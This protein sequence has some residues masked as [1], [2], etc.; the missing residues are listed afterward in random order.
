MSIDENNGFNSNTLAMEIDNGYSVITDSDGNPIIHAGEVLEGFMTSSAVTNNKVCV[1][2]ASATE[3][4]ENGELFTV[5][6]TPSAAEMS[7]Y[8]TTESAATIVT[9]AQN[10]ARSAGIQIGDVDYNGSINSM[11]AASL[12]VACGRNQIGDSNTNIMPILYAYLKRD[13]S[14]S[15][16][17]DIVGKYR[18][19]YTDENNTE[20]PID[21]R[22]MNCYDESYCVVAANR[23]DTRMINGNDSQE[24]LKYSA[25]IGSGGSYTGMVGMDIDSVET[26]NTVSIA[27]NEVAVTATTKSII[28]EYNMNVPILTT[29]TVDGNNTYWLPALI[30][31]YNYTNNASLNPVDVYHEVAAEYTYPTATAWV[32][33]TAVHLNMPIIGRVV[34]PM[35][36]VD[37]YAQINNDNPIYCQFTD[38]ITNKAVLICG[39]TLYSDGTGAYQIMNPE[40]SS[41]K[42]F[43]IVSISEM[44]DG[45]ALVY[46]S[47][48]YTWEQ[49]YY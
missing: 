13:Y 21:P 7:I 2:A 6:L 32:A 29:L 46:P 20:K 48:N 35:D 31:K 3:T 1:A 4:F 11:D 43:T 26:L 17:A 41:T 45:S 34:E 8:R 10:N 23:V 49:A 19:F 38:E 15:A 33:A 14:G 40:I 28:Y 9:A 44:L 42:P 16:G 12:M 22:C 36:Y 27:E 18:L 37:V 5:Y 39:Y 25:K 47:D 30:Y 24:I